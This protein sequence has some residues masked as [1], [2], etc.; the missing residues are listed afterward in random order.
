MGVPAERE[1]NA[2]RRELWP[3]FGVVREGNHRRALRHARERTLYIRRG[4]RRPARAARWIASA[5][6]RDGRV[7]AP[8][9]VRV[10][11]EY[12]AEIGGAQCTLHFVPA[13]VDVVISGNHVDAERCR[14]RS[15]CPRVRRDVFGAVVDQVTGDGNQI[16]R[17]IARCV[18]DAPKKAARCV[19]PDVQVGELGNPQPLELGR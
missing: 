15:Q 1:R 13:G 10:V 18:N 9:H 12:G 8:Q 4:A 3:Q 14:H 17:D 7:A 11:H 2:A 6:E 5:D 16:R 19:R